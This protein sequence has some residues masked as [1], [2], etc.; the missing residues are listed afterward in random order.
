VTERPVQTAAGTM[1]STPLVLIDLETRE[2]II[3][4]S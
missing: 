1:A 4:R 2:G 3:G